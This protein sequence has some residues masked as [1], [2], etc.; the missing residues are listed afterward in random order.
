MKINI[1]LHDN[2]YLFSY[3]KELSSRKEIIIF[4]MIILL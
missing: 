4:V 2:K 3:K 1:F